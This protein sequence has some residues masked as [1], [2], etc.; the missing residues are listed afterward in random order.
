MEKVKKTRP[1]RE[2]KTTVSQTPLSGER[3]EAL[4]R[5]FEGRRISRFRLREAPGKKSE[6]RR[7]GKKTLPIHCQSSLFKRI[8]SMPDAFLEGGKKEGD[9][10]HFRAQGRGGE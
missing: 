9:T 6:S 1:I 8:V 7:H 3:K 5:L 10:S 2:K 4:I